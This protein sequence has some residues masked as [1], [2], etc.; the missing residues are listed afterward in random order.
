MRKL[1]HRHW[2]G[3]AAVLIGAI[4]ASAMALA[5]PA[6]AKTSRCLVV[7]NALNASYTSLQAAQ[8]AAS[9]ADT[10]WVRG[11]C[12]GTTTVRKDLTITGQQPSGYTPPTLDGAGQGSVLTIDPGVTA[13][14]DTLTISHGKT[15][16]IGGGIFYRGTVTV[17]KSTV[18]DNTANL[19]GGVGGDG[20][21]TVND[22]TVSGNTGDL[23]VGIF[24][25]GTATVN[26]SSRIANNTSDGDAGG[27]NNYGGGATLTLNDSSTVTG[28]TA[29][30]EGG[31]IRNDEGTVTLNDSSAIT[32]NTAGDDGGGIWNGGA[33]TLNDSSAI[34][35]N[36][37][38]NVGGGV[39]NAPGYGTLALAGG[40]VS[41]N[42]PDDIYP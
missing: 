14:V 3:S 6:A 5:T 21:L 9:A 33:V 10:L 11:T 24:N 29:D 8:D 18:S 35:S 39:Y 23:G 12:V 28:N 38:G 1:K 16:D 34:T 30:Q 42:T 32:G 20:T 22:S 40:S 17:N 2:P 26:G 25:L 15:S 31:G 7:N 13:A 4:A 27:I 19:G 36:T 37:A 41:G